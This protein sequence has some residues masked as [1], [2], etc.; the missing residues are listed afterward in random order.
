MNNN[1]TKG[2][3]LIVDDTPIN[4][5]LLSNI[6]KMSGYSPRSA[7]SG[8][9][10]LQSVY[11]NPPDLILMDIN[12]PEMN[13]F[14]VCLQLKT[15]EKLKNI[16][17]IFIS[18][19]TDTEDKIKAFE[20]GGQDYI[21]KPFHAEEV[22]ARVDTHMKIRRYQ[23]ELTEKSNSLQTALDKLKATQKQLVQSEK[24]ASLGTLTAGI[25][26]EIN[27]PINFIKTSAEAL[28]QDMDDT[29]RL[30][31]SIDECSYSCKDALVKERFK[32]IKSEIRY[33]IIRHELPNLVDNIT[34]GVSRTE[35]IIKGLRTY[36]RPDK[37]MKIP[38]ELD[39]LINTALVLLKGK[40]KGKVIIEKDYSNLPHVSTQPGRLIQVLS[41]IIGNA[42]DAVTNDFKPD[43][44]KIKIK[45]SIETKDNKGRFVV[46]RVSDNGPGFSQDISEKIFDPF[47]TTKEVGKGQGLGM[48]ISYGIIRDHNGYIEINSVGE[49]GATVSI[50]LPIDLEVS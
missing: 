7:I 2:S 16:P 25:A 11:K 49:H 38:V 40:Y 9:I 17:V 46:V 37:E 19:L 22:L 47:F 39:E 33:D 23:I 10:A 6:L 41:N 24:M 4:L 15:N 28:K 1:H 13:G 50:F 43:E 48:S 44:P 32:I 36:S 8:Q 31:D 12:M 18:A 42:I 20:A 30:L 21:T 35:E 45:T 34:M 5:H 27:N 3:I 26:H 29:R 14:E